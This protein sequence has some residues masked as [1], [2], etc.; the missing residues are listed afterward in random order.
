VFTLYTFGNKFGKE[1]EKSTNPRSSETYTPSET[2]PVKDIKSLANI[3][4]SAVESL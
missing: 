3:H 2:Y 4:L 1:E